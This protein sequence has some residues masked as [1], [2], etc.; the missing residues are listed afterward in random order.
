VPD[1][2]FISDFEILAFTASG[3]GTSNKHVPYDAHHINLMASSYSDNS[4]PIHRN[5]LLGLV[6]SPDQSAEGQAA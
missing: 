6:S 1:K 5:R 4:E 2:L 3:D